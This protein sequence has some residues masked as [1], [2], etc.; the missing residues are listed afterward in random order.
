MSP[1]IN[2]TPCFRAVAGGKWGMFVQLIYFLNGRDSLLKLLEFSEVSDTG[3]D[4][5]AE[6]GGCFRVLHSHS[7]SGLR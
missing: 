4:R 3:H 5:P 1:V 6:S 7:D 2:G